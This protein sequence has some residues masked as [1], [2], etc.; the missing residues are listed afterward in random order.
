MENSQDTKPLMPGWY[1]VLAILALLW[2]LMGCAAFATEIF[3]QEAMIKEW[4]PAQQKWARTIPTP[5]YFVY[6]LAVVTGV[7]GS[8]GLIIRKRWSGL[9][10]ASSFVAVVI[11][12]VYT[13]IIAG[14]VRVMGPS[15]VVMPAVVIIIAGGLVWFSLFARRKG[16]LG[17]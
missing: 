7:A 9:F 3:A 11:Q 10:F 8:I 6:G 2:N 13:M 5:I 14:G 17:G 4:E 15:S 1:R 16:W 12:M